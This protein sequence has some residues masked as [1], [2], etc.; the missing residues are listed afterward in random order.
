LKT[1]YVLLLACA[2]SIELNSQTNLQLSS[3]KENSLN[4]KNNLNPTR[5][6]LGIG[7][8]ND[9]DYHGIKHLVEFNANI[10]L[11]QAFYINIGMDVYSHPSND[12]GAETFG[13]FLAPNL[14]VLENSEWITMFV[15][16]GL[17]LYH[18]SM[19]PE[20]GALI[21]SRGEYNISKRF[22]TGL[23][24][25]MAIINTDGSKDKFV[26]GNVYIAV[27]F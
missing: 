13:V 5:L 10:N 1:I 9:L 23:E 4:S 21:F 27:R 19:F 8:I 3:L 25:K 11:Y 18:P 17:Y 20:L 2:L 15:G 16:A 22:S 12:R 14:S 6:M 7:I 24:V 26:S